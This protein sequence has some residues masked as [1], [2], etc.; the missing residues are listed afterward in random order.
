MPEAMWVG[1]VRRKLAV[2]EAGTCRQHFQ[3]STRLPEQ[4]ISVSW[5]SLGTTV[6]VV[7]LQDT[8]EQKLVLLWILRDRRAT[9]A[10]QIFSVQ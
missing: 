1:A 6:K 10:K 7:L 2:R 8:Q 3:P 4:V 5:P 9:K